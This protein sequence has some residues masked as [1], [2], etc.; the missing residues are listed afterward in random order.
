MKLVASLLPS[1]KEKE[2]HITVALF[3]AP[4]TDDLEFVL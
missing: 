1:V 3:P 4:I 2:T